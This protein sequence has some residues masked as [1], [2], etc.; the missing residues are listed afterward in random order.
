M[1]RCSES[2]PIG[3][4]RRALHCRA[5]ARQRSRYQLDSRRRPQHHPVRTIPL[6]AHRVGSKSRDRRRRWA[7]LAAAWLRCRGRVVRRQS[8]FQHVYVGSAADRSDRRCKTVSVTLSIGA[9][10]VRIPVRTVPVFRH[11]RILPRSLGRVHPG[12]ARPEIER[13]RDENRPRADCFLRSSEFLVDVTAA[14]PPARY[15]PQ[16]IHRKQNL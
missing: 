2:Q 13:H 7:A 4:G 3:V 5:R 6:R 8:P 15:L 10:V 11:G 9:D 1:S 16:P 14:A 12:H